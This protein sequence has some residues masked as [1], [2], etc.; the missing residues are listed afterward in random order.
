MALFGLD[1]RVPPVGV[2]VARK[3]VFIQHPAPAN[4]VSYT[5]LSTSEMVDV[6][7]PKVTVR[8]FGATSA[9]VPQTG[10]IVVVPS[11]RVVI[12][13]PEIVATLVSE[14]V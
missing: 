4:S 5:L 12:L 1:A 8:V 13:V 14:L 6:P 10:V 9:Q 3:F 11:L 7:Q 2:L